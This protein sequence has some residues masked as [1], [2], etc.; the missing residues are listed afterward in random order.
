VIVDGAKAASNV[1]G[2]VT[3]AGPSVGSPEYA[4][5]MEL[6]ATVSVNV[7]TP[8]TEGLEALAP[9]V[10]AMALQPWIGT[11]P[12]RKATVPVG[13]TE[14]PGDVATTFAV[15]EIAS[16]TVRPVVPP[17]TE[18]EVLVAESTPV[19]SSTEERLA[20]KVLSPG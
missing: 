4:A 15:T 3:V 12:S 16:P 7:R 17:V 14:A 11:P 1:V 20:A 19:N 18:A 2:P 6:S 8:D 5:A 9:W 13:A 10:S